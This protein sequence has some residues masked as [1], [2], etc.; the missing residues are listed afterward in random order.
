[1]DA[2]AGHFP[3]RFDGVHLGGVDDVSGAELA[4]EFQL[5]SH[6]IDGDDPA[7][8]GDVG[9]VDAG[10]PHAAAADH[11]H[12][13]TRLDPCRVDHGPHA[14]GDAAADEGRPVERNV[15]ANLGD[16]VLVHQ[17]LLGERGE[18]EKL[19][20]GATLAG[21]AWRLVYAARQFRLLTQ[22][23]VAGE[24]E[25]AVAAE[26][27]QASDDVVA[28]LNVGDVSPHGLHHP[29]RLVAEDGWARVGIGAVL[30]VQVG[31][32]HPGCSGANEHFARARVR[33]L[34]ILDRQRLG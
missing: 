30:E 2:A 33:G 34:N 11:R 20:D 25:L 28:G 32:T 15:L 16:G 9:A 31:V 29:G 1:M 6:P 17:H 19:R 27:R 23:H 10:K 18:V 12:G 3:H 5:G 7:R 21:K 8:A 14:R 4:R 22:R 13:G 26:G 24:A